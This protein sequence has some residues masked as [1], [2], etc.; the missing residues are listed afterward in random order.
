M[1]DEITT[2]E[3]PGFEGCVGCWKRA[4]TLYPNNITLCGGILLEPIEPSKDIIRLCTYKT[5]GSEHIGCHTFHPKEVLDVASMINLLVG[6]MLDY[7]DPDDIVNVA[8]GNI[9]VVF[10]KKRDEE[11]ER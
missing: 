1:S 5:D 11:N 8:R 7:I 10:E 2:F 4:E 3:D 9:G 6:D